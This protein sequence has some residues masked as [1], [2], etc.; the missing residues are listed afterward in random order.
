MK[1]LSMVPSHPSYYTRI[2]STTNYRVVTDQEGQGL[3]SY[4][5]MALQIAMQ[6]SCSN[7]A[8]IQITD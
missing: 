6:S 7:S 1:H 4:L 2:F 5:F 8:R 3:V